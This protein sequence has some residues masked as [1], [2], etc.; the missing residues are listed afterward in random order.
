VTQDRPKTNVLWW[1]VPAAVII[2]LALFASFGGVQPPQRPTPNSSLDASPEGTRAVYLMLDGLGYNVATSRMLGAGRVRWLLFPRAAEDEST[3][4][5]DDGVPRPKGARRS[6][7]ADLES[8]RHWVEEGGTLVLADNSP[9]FAQSLGLRVE[10]LTVA[11]ARIK[12]DDSHPL[13]LA[14]GRTLISAADQPN[15]DWPTRGEPLASVFKR[16]RGEIWII[17]RPGIMTNSRIRDA[18]NAMAICRLADATGHDGN[19]RIFIDEYFHGM[20]QRPGPMQLI[21]QPPALWVT[22]Q[23]LGVLALLMWRFLPHFGPFREDAPVRRR[24]K[25]EFLDAM[26]YLLVR[27]GA[28]ADAAQAIR[29]ALARDLENALGLPASVEPAELAKYAAAR[30]PGVDEVAL[31][32]AL[33]R[34]ESPHGR[35][36]FLRTLTELESLRR[37]FFHE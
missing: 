14:P 18:D 9:D 19:E 26:A 15:R 2:L 5:D 36:G 34:T 30:R 20:R 23:A 21:F 11:D 8:L 6:H 25:E 29:D 1:A 33:A 27:K 7:T 4:N 17:Q 37:E 35:D 16:G 24:S 3:F 31:A 13:E 28:Y 32:R 12:I 22:L 10:S